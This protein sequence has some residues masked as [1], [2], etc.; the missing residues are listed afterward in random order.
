MPFAKTR[1]SLSRGPSA[2]EDPYSVDKLDQQIANA[3]LRA[4][5]AGFDAN[6]DKRNWFEKWSN[7]PQG[8]NG[9]LDTLEILGRPG[10]AVLNAIDKVPDGD[11]N[12]GEAAWRGFS[13]KDRVRGSE[14]FADRGLE[15][16]FGKAVLGTGLEIVTDPLNAI[17]AGWIA[18]GA[19]AVTRPVRGFAKSAYNTL[20]EAA[21]SVKTFRTEKVAPVTD[22]VHRGFSKVFKYQSGW[23]DTL[24][25][26]KTDDLKNLYDDTL[27]TM[28]YDVEN[29]TR[30]VVNDA[31]VTGLDAGNDVGR[32]MEK[33]LRINRNPDEL[34]GDIMKGRPLQMNVAGGELPD[35]LG[36]MNQRILNSKPVVERISRKSD[37]LKQ[38][39]DRIAKLMDEHD[40]DEVATRY[41][42]GDSVSDVEEKMLERLAKYRKGRD[43][44]VRDIETTKRGITVNPL[45]SSAQRMK[46]EGF[47]VVNPNPRLYK[48]ALGNQAKFIDEVSPKGSFDKVVK[49]ELQPTLKPIVEKLLQTGK[50]ATSNIKGTPEAK[51][52]RRIFGNNIGMLHKK[53]TTITLR[54]NNPTMKYYNLEGAKPVIPESLTDANKISPGQG[55][56]FDDIQ[57]T[58]RME[59]VNIPRPD[60]EFSESPM[61]NVVAKRLL[62][63]NAEIREKATA[64]GITIPEIEGYMK[65]ILTEA[66]RKA[67]QK[68]GLQGGNFGLGNPNKSVLK[69]RKYEGSAEDVNELLDKDVFQTNAYFATAVGQKQ[70]IEY[71][72]AESFKRQVLSDKRFAVPYKK[73]MEV[74]KGQ[75]VIN[76]DQF[77]FFK[78]TTPD[79]SQ[80]LSVGKGQEY[81]VTDGVKEALDRL[82]RAFSD[83]GINTLIRGIDKVQTMWKKLALFSVPYHIRNDIGAKFNMYVGG[84]NP[85]DLGKYTL[86]GYETVA[87]EVLRERG[88]KNLYV[89]PLFEEYRKQGLS[90]TNISNVEF[91]TYKDPETEIED[92]VKDRSRTLGQQLNDRINP[93]SANPKHVFVNWKTVK[94]SFET[95]REL[96]DFIDQSH[97]FALFKW[98]T[99]KKGMNPKQAAEKVRE[100]L[101]D[102]TRTTTAEREVL[103]RMF[104][105]Y[106]WVRFNLPYQLKMFAND[107]AKYSNINK[108]RLNAQD[109]AGINEEETPEFL[110]EQFAVPVSES[111][112]LGLNLPLGDLTK[113]SDPLKLGADSLTPLIKTPLELATNFNTF[114]RKPIEKF[115]GQRKQYE[116]AGMEGSLPIKGAYALEQATG[117]I[118]RGFSQYLQKSGDVD[119]DTKFRMPKMGI[120]SILKDYDAAQSQYFEKL[121]ELRKLQDYMSYIEQQTGNRPRSVRE[122]K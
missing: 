116:F 115:E 40:L 41:R 39:D 70:L 15:S 58:N 10:Q 53:N 33:D 64:T 121:Q 91:K 59:N 21:P 48:K 76:P 51:E 1:G 34:V 68:K 83:E 86:E 112:F 93:L 56:Q 81:L 42:D 38:V 109:A 84:M 47:E 102:Y 23:D 108:I 103:A 25:G 5:D 63:S 89:D 107:P 7:L 49:P 66:A 29:S 118:G 14:I 18:K 4:Q 100:V 85:I 43:A 13:G 106:R 94:N 45:E 67:K 2:V 105:F 101:F 113:L 90:S 77:K 119:Q 20:E 16:G 17:P 36:S 50:V 24:T 69:R 111:K 35:L 57:L 12:L 37:Q 11:R 82:N 80:L 54:Q 74:Q 61:T 120:G 3:R 97:R 95:S 55:L 19:S 22:A 87:K 79:G 60:R 44:L 65:H 110:R 78:V 46:G 30:K 27:N 114:Y 6:P 99:Q 32:V 26:S 88:G 52:L 92:I 62:E 117:Q 96:G 72:A 71:I 98:A 8:Q 73:G 122:I 31:R 28:K 75:H 9:F 104:P